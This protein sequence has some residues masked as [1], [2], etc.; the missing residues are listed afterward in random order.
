MFMDIEVYE[1]FYA[2]S[3]EIR[4]K[5]VYLDRNLLILEDN[6]LGFGNFGIVK[7]GYY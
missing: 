4:F 7:K 6:E 1:S 3:E 2:D 5:E